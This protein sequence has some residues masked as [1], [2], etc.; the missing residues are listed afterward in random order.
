[1]S[2]VR[3]Q[4]RNKKGNDED[5]PKKRGNQGDFKGQREEFLQ[6]NLPAYM[7]ASEAGTTREFWPDFFFAW[8]KKF[9]WWLDLKEEP[10]E[11][12]EERQKDNKDLTDAEKVVK[13]ETLEKMERCYMQQPDPRERIQKVFGERHPDKVNA[14]GHINKRAGIACELLAQ[15]NAEVQKQI[16]GLAD[17]EHELVMKEWREARNGT[18]ELDDKEKKIARER[19]AVTVAPLLKI[20]S[21]YTGYHISLIVGRID[22]TTYKFDIRS[23]HEGKTKGR[24]PQD[25]PQWAGTST[26][27]DHV[28]HQFMRF[29]ITADTEPGSPEA[30][31]VG[32]DPIKILRRRGVEAAAAA[33]TSA[34]NTSPSTSGQNLL[35]SPSTT[36]A[37]AS[38]STSTGAQSSSPST[39]IIT[40]ALAAAAPPSP[41]TNITVGAP[42]AAAAPTTGA[43]AAATTPT[44]GAP[45]AAA[46][47][48]AGAPTTAAPPWDAWCSGNKQSTC[49]SSVRKL[50]H[51]VAV[52]APLGASL[53]CCG[54]ISPGVEDHQVRIHSPSPTGLRMSGRLPE[55]GRGISMTSE[56]LLA[57]FR[58]SAFF[59]AFFFLRSSFISALSRRC[60]SA[61]NILT[62]LARSS[63]RNASLALR[64]PPFPV[65]IAP[66]HRLSLHWTLPSPAPLH[67]L[68]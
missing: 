40:G 42:A 52:F 51:R 23:L 36:I 30:V 47:H 33:S 63:L 17:A 38:S 54:I 68:H 58:F 8:W 28:V 49:P 22:M 9:P 37:G 6:E 57:R 62:P 55:L 67:V 21:E 3:Q 26:Y 14:R 53:A 29:L 11:D 59:S 20:L 4:R 65:A 45:T 5:T 35:L 13:R 24:N 34:Q 10:P 60:S 31:F 18:G 43:P 2:N 7:L 39:N 19:W 48:T 1:M 32:E 56:L 12:M 41:S 44:T 64:S 46:A 27:N 66:C 61:I 50:M 16:T 25:W 15:E